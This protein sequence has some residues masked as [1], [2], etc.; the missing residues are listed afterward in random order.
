MSVI[1]LINR[2]DEVMEAFKNLPKNG[3]LVT[4]I[5]RATWVTTIQTDINAQLE[6]CR[7]ELEK[8]VI[9]EPFY[10]DFLKKDQHRHIKGCAL[11][12]DLIGHG[13]V[14]LESQG[15]SLTI[16]AR[17]IICI[18]DF[19]SAIEDGYEVM[20]DHLDAITEMMIKLNPQSYENYYLTKKAEYDEAPVRTHY[21]DWKFSVAPVTL[22]LLKSKQTEV[23]AEALIKGLMDYDNSPTTYEK[24]Q[25][26]VE[27][28]KLHLIDDINEKLPAD[29]DVRCAKFRRYITWGDD[30]VLRIDYKNFGRYI[31]RKFNMFTTEQLLALFELDMMLYLIHQDMVKLKPELAQY[32]DHGEQYFPIMKNVIVLLQQ[33]WFAEM[34]TS[35]KYNDEWLERLLNDLMTEWGKEIAQDWEKADKRDTVKCQMIGAIKDAGVIDAGYQDIADNWDYDAAIPA[36]RLAKYLGQGKK[37]PYFNWICDY[38]KS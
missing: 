23:V 18:K 16:N 14:T 36:S 38:V 19:I 26:K 37:Q 4:L 30:Y 7:G 10:H 17:A 21:K 27:K 20:G 22:D 35:K 33:K 29:F 5:R 3:S 32:M 2:V 15:F 13:D 28:V 31:C 6:V 12:K 9:T 11:E 1:Q 25:V 24:Q 34:R 8:G